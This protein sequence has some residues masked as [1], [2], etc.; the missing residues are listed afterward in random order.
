MKCVDCKYSEIKADPDPDDWF[1]QDDQKIVCM[2]ENHRV[3]DCALRPYQTKNVESPD[4]CPLKKMKRRET[5]NE[6][7]Q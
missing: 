1:C 2:A 3:I 5:L 7:L 6:I 4:W